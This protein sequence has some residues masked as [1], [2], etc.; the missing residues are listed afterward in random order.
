MD[1]LEKLLSE[2]SSLGSDLISAVENSDGSEIVRLKEREKT[3]DSDIFAASV[4]ALK[5]QIGEIEAQLLIDQ[6]NIIRAKQLS[7]ETDALVGSQS[8]VLR[9]ELQKI[10]SDAMMKF[11]AVKHAEKQLGDTGFKLAECREKLSKLLNN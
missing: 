3:I 7:K 8:S 2:K 9:E 5:A 4:L 6:Q 11:V 1:N 10:N